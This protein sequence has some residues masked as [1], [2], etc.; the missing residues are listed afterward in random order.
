M[1]EH[2]LQ[3]WLYRAIYASWHK[4]ETSKSPV[5]PIEMGQ[6]QLKIEKGKV[7]NYLINCMSALLEI[8]V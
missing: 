4:G 6:I 5:C 3:T 7:V 8:A 2:K 1:A